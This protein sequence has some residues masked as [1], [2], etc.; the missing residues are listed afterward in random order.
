MPPCSARD[1]THFLMMGQAETAEDIPPIG[2]AMLI[3]ACTGKT[4]LHAYRT[5][6]YIA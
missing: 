3:Y 5:L 2:V 6:S 1:R 4:H